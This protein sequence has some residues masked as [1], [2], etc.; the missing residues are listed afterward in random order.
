MASSSACSAGSSCL[1]YARCESG[2]LWLPQWR[3]GGGRMGKVVSDT[4]GERRVYHRLE[5]TRTSTAQLASE[6][7]SL[8][9]SHRR[10]RRPRARACCHHL[11]RHSSTTSPLASP[12]PRTTPPSYFSTSSAQARTSTAQLASQHNTP[13]HRAQPAQTHIARPSPDFES[14]V[15]RTNHCTESTRGFEGLPFVV[16]TCG[17]FGPS[18]VKLIHAM[19]QAG[20]EHLAV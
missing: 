10:T 7:S 19:A 12:P 18:A 16:E 13:S 5:Q 3:E 9:Y 11:Q 17:G 14:Q 1:A 4:S 6:R 8:M 2:G 20:E 15:S